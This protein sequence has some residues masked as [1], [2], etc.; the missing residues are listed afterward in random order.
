MLDPVTILLGCSGYI[1]VGYQPEVND[2][3]VIFNIRAVISVGETYIPFDVE[4]L[5]NFFIAIRR[6]AEFDNL[7]GAEEYWP[8]IQNEFMGKFFIYMNGPAYTISY[9]NYESWI[10]Y[11]VEFPNKELLVHVLSLERIV[12]GHMNIL[13]ALQD[14]QITLLSKLEELR[15]KCINTPTHVKNMAE[16]SSDKFVVEIATNLFSFFVKYWESKN[17]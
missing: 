13:V 12:S 7:D 11:E 5:A 6:H 16:N 9:I 17:N 1:Q 14:N 10:T 15:L 4:E 3:D 2:D 8:Y